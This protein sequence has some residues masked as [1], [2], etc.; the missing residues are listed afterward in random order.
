M[1]ILTASARRR[2]IAGVAA[3]AAASLTVAA[4]AAAPAQAAPIPVQ[5]VGAQG[6]LS[7][8]LGA[9]SPYAATIRIGTKKPGEVWLSAPGGD[10]CHRGAAGTHVRFDF[11]NV[12]SMRSGSG[13]VRPCPGPFSGP[14]VTTLYTGPGRVVGTITIVNPGPWQIPGGATFSVPG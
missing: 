7:M 12:T 11:Y 13:T 4:L 3:A 5:Q 1:S 9:W 2:R 14:L 10:A 6:V 8:G